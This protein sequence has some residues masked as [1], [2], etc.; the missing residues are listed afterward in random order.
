[1]PRRFLT[2]AMSGKPLS[3]SGLSARVRMLVAAVLL[4]RPPTLGE[5]E[6]EP[7]ALGPLALS[8]CLA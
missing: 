2:Q 7:S 4:R 8:N 5:I 1:M 3:V 6:E